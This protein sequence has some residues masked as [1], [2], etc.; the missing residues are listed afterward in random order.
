MDWTGESSSNVQYNQTWRLKRTVSTVVTYPG[1]ST[2][3]GNRNVGLGITVQGYWNAD[4]GSTLDKASFMYL[5]SPSASTEITYT[6]TMQDTDAITLYNQR[7][8]SDTDHFD[9]ERA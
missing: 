7:T 9:Y 4:A 3:P 6:V 5:D 8:V 1:I 2:S